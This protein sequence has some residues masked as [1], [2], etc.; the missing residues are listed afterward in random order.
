MAKPPAKPPA[1]KPTTTS[2]AKPDAPARKGSQVV[3]IR[4]KFKTA[5]NDPEFSARMARHLQDLL[6]QGRED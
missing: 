2:T 3:A 5:M 1:K 6:R 4:E